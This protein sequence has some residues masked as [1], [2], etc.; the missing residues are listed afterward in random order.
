MKADAMTNVTDDFI[1]KRSHCVPTVNDVPQ[2]MS[3]VVLLNEI[4]MNLQD[5][6]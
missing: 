4:L 1:K 2:S 5:I 6:R 3:A